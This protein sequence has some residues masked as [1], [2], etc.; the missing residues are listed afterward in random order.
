MIRGQG[1]LSSGETRDGSGA[2]LILVAEEFE[3]RATHQFFFRGRSGIEHDHIDIV[4]RREF[5]RDST[6]QWL[7]FYPNLLS[8]FECHTYRG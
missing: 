3:I 7:V 6:G 4:E 8:F 5:F 1:D 2:V